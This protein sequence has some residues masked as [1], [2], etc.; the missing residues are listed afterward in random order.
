M[1]IPS[2]TPTV[3]SLP[4]LGGADMIAFL[5]ANNVWIIGVDGSGLS[6]LTT[7]G[8][9]K[10]DLQWMPDGQGVLYIT[11]KCIQ[12]VNADTKEV[13]D[14]TC[15]PAADY[16][17]A[18]QLSLDGAQVAISLN[19]ELY[20]VPFDLDKLSQARSHTDLAAM[21]GCLTYTKLATKGVRWSN[22]GQKIAVMVQGVGDNGLFEDMVYVMDIHRCSAAEPIR[23]DIF[24]ATRFNMTGFN[25]NP[26][27]PSFNWDGM[28]LFLLNS[29]YRNDGYGYLY[30]YNLESH[31]ATALDPL[32]STC[33]YRDARWSPNG[34]YILFAYQ[35]I[36]LGANSPIQLFYIPYGTIGTG[37]TYTPFSL[38]AGFFQKLTEKPQP[39]LRPAR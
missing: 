25:S 18:F 39:A 28:T 5:N 12:I 30:G 13:R 1:I 37:A 26:V 19:R 6:Q 17:E 8:A 15:F 24:P 31:K 3:A 36:R 7:D 34:S 32:G 16:L 21:N 20:V 33:C 27:I 2:L 10:H 22:D 38:P 9:V 4:T 29:F 23:L 11:G 35:D 14:L